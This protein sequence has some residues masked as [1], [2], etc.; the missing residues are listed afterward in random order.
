MHPPGK[1]A[2]AVLLLARVLGPI[3]LWKHHPPIFLLGGH[4]FLLFVTAGSHNYTPHF[5][6]CDSLGTWLI[7]NPPPPPTGYHGMGRPC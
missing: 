3:F 6:Y 1:V 7:I 2:Q 4:L 5:F